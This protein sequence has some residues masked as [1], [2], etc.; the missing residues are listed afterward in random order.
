MIG[1]KIKMKD[2]ERFEYFFFSLRLG[3]FKMK[4]KIAQRIRWNCVGIATAFLKDFVAYG[5]ISVTAC[6]YLMECFDKSRSLLGCKKDLL[7]SV[8]SRL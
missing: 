2:A 4:E 5:W 8:K 7:H 3:K 6:F 1:E